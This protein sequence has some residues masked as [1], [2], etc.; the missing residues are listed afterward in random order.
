MGVW[1]SGGAPGHAIHLKLSMDS[2]IQFAFYLTVLIFSVVIHEVSHGY[3][4]L[5][6]G[7][8]TAK[9]E[10]RLTLNPIPHLDTFGSIIL[11]LLLSIPLLF[12][13]PS[14]LFGW[15]KPVPY[16]PYNL[17]NQKWGPAIVAVAGPLANISL[18]VLFG[19]V[20]RFLPLASG[21]L[22]G[23]FILNFAS[24]A[25]VVVVLNLVL[26][27]FNLVPIPPLDG[28]KLLFAVLPYRYS[29]VRVF[30]ERHGFLL[31]LVFIFFFAGNIIFPVVLFF[32]RLITGTLPFF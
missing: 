20:V 7:D 28:S 14:I 11:P 8:K 3:A 6:L 27:F 29:N 25:S 5:L 4:A 32:F 13:Q 24:I 18:A 19:L 26:A 15:A 10:G 21:T 16:N 1:F 22:P 23:L 30:L 17:R 31:L 2:I 9:Y 12:G